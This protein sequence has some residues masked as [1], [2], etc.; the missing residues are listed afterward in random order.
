MFVTLT[1]NNGMPYIINTA[2]ILYIAHDND[3]RMRTVVVMRDD[4]HLVIGDKLSV[5]A[6]LMG[7]S[8]AEN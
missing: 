6:E 1:G 4:R 3:A 7:V 8:C 5:V 2:N